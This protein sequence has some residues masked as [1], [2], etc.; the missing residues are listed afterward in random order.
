MP[1]LP[2]QETI[3]PSVAHPELFPLTQ[4][5]NVSLLVGRGCA[6]VC[7]LGSSKMYFFP[8]SSQEQKWK[9]VS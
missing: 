8:F 4:Q 2:W 9:E 7:I 6:V 1:H 5:T 3:Y